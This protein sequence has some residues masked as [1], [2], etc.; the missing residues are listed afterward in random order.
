MDQ[1]SSSE[2]ETSDGVDLE[3]ERELSGVMRP[4]ILS[5]PWAEVRGADVKGDCLWSEGVKGE[6]VGEREDFDSAGDSGTVVN[7]VE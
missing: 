7:I 5:A 6:E 3:R 2:R 4:S 1:S